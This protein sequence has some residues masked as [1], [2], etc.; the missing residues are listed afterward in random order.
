MRGDT[1]DRYEEFTRET[2]RRLEL[3]R[4]TYGDRSFSA[5]PCVLLS[6]LAQEA[7]DL[8]GW[9]YVLWHRVEALRA[10]LAA[11]YEPSQQ[12]AGG[13]SRGRTVTLPKRVLDWARH[14][15]KRRSEEAGSWR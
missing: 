8:A 2:R 10:A 1:L 6:E 3:G 9:G 4:E 12:Q 5:D 11:S 7:L 13:E 15:V 14:E